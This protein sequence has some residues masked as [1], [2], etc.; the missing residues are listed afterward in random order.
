[1]LTTVRFFSS[2]Y[3]HVHVVCYP[4][5][6]ALPAVLAPVLL[7][8]PVYLHVR[9]EVPSVVKI[10]TALR[11]SRCELPGAFVNRPVIFVVPQLGKLLPTL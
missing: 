9:A 7:P 2:V 10:L 4:L 5:V 6:E 11:A 1:M 8:V 3:S